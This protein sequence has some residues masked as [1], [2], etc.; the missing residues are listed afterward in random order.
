MHARTKKFHV[1]NKHEKK[2]KKEKILKF[3]ATENWKP[4]KHAENKNIYIYI[5]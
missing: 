4:F 5:Y 3:R 2:E 1:I